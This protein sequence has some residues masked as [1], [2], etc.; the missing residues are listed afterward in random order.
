MKPVFKFN[1]F[2][3]ISFAVLCGLFYWLCP[4]ISHAALRYV[5][6]G[7]LMLGAFCACFLVVKPK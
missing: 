4:T 5:V 7:V 6:Y 1:A 3:V 2:G